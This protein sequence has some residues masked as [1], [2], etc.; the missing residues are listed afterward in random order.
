[1]RLRSMAWL[2][3]LLVSLLTMNVSHGGE[4]PSMKDCYDASNPEAANVC[5]LAAWATYQAVQVAQVRYGM[6]AKTCQFDINIS[7]DQLVDQV[8]TVAAYAMERARPGDEISALMIGVLTTPVTCRPGV[9]TAVGGMTRTALID[10]CSRAFKPDGNPRSCLAYVSSLRNSFYALSGYEG[11]DK[12]FCPPNAGIEQK[13][14]LQLFLAE[15]KR[16]LV[17]REG[18]ANIS[19]GEVM[20]KALSGAYACHK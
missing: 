4:K 11:A 16:E 14:A 12:F 8:H 17:A 2:C 20:A 1:M 6:K 19:A 3:V 15:S 9:A 5:R 13:E 18:P 7:A 10:L